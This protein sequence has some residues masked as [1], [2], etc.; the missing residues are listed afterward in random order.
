MLLDGRVSFPIT[1]FFDL[2]SGAKFEQNPKMSLSVRSSP[3][4]P[5]MPEMDFFNG[6]MG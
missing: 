6:T 1:H 3:K 2:I 4:I 5:R